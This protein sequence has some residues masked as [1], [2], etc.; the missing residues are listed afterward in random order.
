MQ[1]P[2]AG[3]KILHCLVV[4]VVNNLENGESFF[5]IMSIVDKEFL[6]FLVADIIRHQEVNFVDLVNNLHLFPE[7]RVICVE[8]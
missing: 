5:L 1:D 6:V 4:E 8:L 7:E 2:D 3:K